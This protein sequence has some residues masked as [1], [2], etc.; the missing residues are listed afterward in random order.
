MFIAPARAS[1][2]GRRR[3]PR[4]RQPHCPVVELQVVPGRQ[5]VCT[6]VPPSRQSVQ[7]CEPSQARL[8]GH[9]GDEP[10][11]SPVAGYIMQ[12][13]GGPMQSPLVPQGGL[14]AQ[15]PLGSGSLYLAPP[16]IPSF[17]PLAFRAAEQARHAPLQ[18]VSQ[19]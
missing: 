11:P 5:R 15:S 10:A 13:A 6:G 14:S 7:H 16:Q 18:V 12:A 19:Q 8:F 9:E 1:D 17:T 3:R 2:V 4:G